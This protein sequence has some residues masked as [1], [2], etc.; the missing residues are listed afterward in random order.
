MLPGI[1]ARVEPIWDG[2]HAG[3]SDHQPVV[4]DLDHQSVS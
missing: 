4:V 3:L 2:D 1:D